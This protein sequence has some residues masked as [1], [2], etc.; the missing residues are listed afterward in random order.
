[1]TGSAYDDALS[2]STAFLL[3]GAR[4]VIGALWYVPMASTGLLMFMFHH[5][6]REEPG[7]PADAM[8]CAQLWMLDPDRTF[9]PELP[10]QL[11]ESVALRLLPD[12]YRWAG[13]SHLGR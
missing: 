2:Q 7:R 12:P 9:P 5:Y 4:A 8:R 11:S 6:L 10:A 1:M 13:F 3:A